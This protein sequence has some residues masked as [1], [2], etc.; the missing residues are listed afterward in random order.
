MDKKKNKMELLAPARDFETLESAVLFGADAVYIGVQTLSLRSAADFA[1]DDI[2]SAADFA[3]S[4]NVKLYLACNAVPYNSEISC[5][6]DKIENIRKSGIDA[7]IL[8]DLG[9][10]G[11]VKKFAPEIPIHISTQAG[12]MNYAAAEM[13]RNLGASRVIPARELSLRDIAVISEKCETEVFVHGAMCMSVSGRCLLSKYM[14]NRDANLG[15]CAHSCRWNYALVE[16]TRPNDAMP[17]YEENGFSYILNSKD[18]C[19]I[20]HI[21]EIAEAGVASIKIEGRGKSAYYVAVITNAYRHALDCHYNGEPLEE[22]IKDEVHAV[23]HR[24]YCEGFF[25]GT[26]D[27][28]AIYDKASG[29]ER[30]Y[31][32]VGV[33]EGD[34]DGG[35][36]VRQRNFFTAADELEILSP[37]GKPEKLE[38]TGIFDASGNT[39]ETANRAEQILTF[40]SGRTYPKK[41]ILRKRKRKG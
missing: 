13:L 35:F 20:E 36:T 23:S 33:T 28:A 3:H 9:M 10:F 32:F 6:S 22:W 16:E 24:K 17:V 37:C 40:L 19:M 1:E 8:S 41:S 38:F 15:N 29:Y 2:K 26:P 31:D 4:R 12:V 18:L 14:S 11:L 27:D 5:F 25:F 7:V 30:D 39:V 21:P 34:A